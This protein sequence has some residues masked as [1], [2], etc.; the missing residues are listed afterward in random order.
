ML[1]K[2]VR[3]RC[4]NIIHFH[5]HTTIENLNQQLLLSSMS[6]SGLEKNGAG[7]KRDACFQS[8]FFRNRTRWMFSISISRDGKELKKIKKCPPIAK[9]LKGRQILSS[10]NWMIEICDHRDGYSSSRYLQ[11]ID[12]WLSRNLIIEKSYAWEN[13]LSRKQPF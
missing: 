3:I 12:F 7:A 2:N 8:R 1:L 9:D 13:E 11:I 4:N 6:P 5:T 10:S